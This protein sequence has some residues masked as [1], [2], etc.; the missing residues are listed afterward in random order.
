MR[1][2]PASLAHLLRREPLIVF[3]LIGGGLFLAYHLLHA[4]DGRIE[5]SHEIQAGLAEDYATLSG[6]R[7]GAAEKKM[8]TD[9]YIADELLFREAVKRGVHLTDRSIR[10]RMID[11]M[12][13][14]T[15]KQP[16]DPTET[17]LRSYYAKHPGLYQIEPSMS[18]DHVFFA[19]APENDVEILAHLD[20]GQAVAGD[21]FWMGH[22]MSRYGESMISSM[23]GLPFL[24]TLRKAPTAMWIGPVKSSRG[25]HFV[26][27]NRRFGATRRPYG[28]VRDQ[29]RQD[30]LT[31]ASQAALATEVARLKKDYAIVVAP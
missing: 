15:V 27:V 1:L 5:V 9:N 21:D 4:R 8:V 24:D 19:Q 23:F 7:P 25:W 30:Y 17:Q 6:H 3:L 31:S 29:V 22:A 16:A 11:K 2:F 26:R 10:Q 13:F 14:L 20:A 18:F 28:E 12:R